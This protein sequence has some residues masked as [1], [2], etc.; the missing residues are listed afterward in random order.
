M[1]YRLT[2]FGVSVLVF[3]GIMEDPMPMKKI[4]TWKNERQVD[5]HRVSRECF[6]L[7]MYLL[8]I[9]LFVYLFNIVD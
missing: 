9:Y 1:P 4:A 2:G 3:R 8:L 6:Y 5:L 7:F